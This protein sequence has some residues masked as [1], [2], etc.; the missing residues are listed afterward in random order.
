M[1]KW[2]S[3]VLTLSL[4][5]ISCSHKAITSSGF[6]G[7]STEMEPTITSEASSL[8]S[9][10]S[11]MVQQSVS[12]EGVLAE[13]ADSSSLHLTSTTGNQAW[14]LLLKPPPEHVIWPH[15]A[16]GTQAANFSRIQSS[17]TTGCAAL[18]VILICIRIW[19]QVA[20]SQQSKAFEHLEPCKRGARL[21]MYD[22]NVGDA[23]AM[24]EACAT[25][26][27]TWRSASIYLCA[28][29][30]YMCAGTMVDTIGLLFG[31]FEAE[32]GKLAPNR[33]ACLSL[34][35][36]TGQILADIFAG[37][38]ADAR[39]RCFVARYASILVV[40]YLVM[41][42][43]TPSLEVLALAR[44]FGGLGVGTMNAIFPTLLSECVPRHCRYLLVMYQFGWPFGAAIFTQIMAH[45]GWRMA[46]ASFLP[47][48]LLV[49]VIF[50]LPGWLPESPKWLCSQ[51]RFQEAAEAAMQLGASRIS[52]KHVDG[53]HQPYRQA[54]SRGAV[55][56]EQPPA[57]QSDVTNEFYIRSTIG[58]FGFASAAVLTKVW[59]PKVL[60][61]RGVQ[62]NH[63]SFSTMWLVESG[64][65]VVSGLLLGN[66][67]EGKDSNRSSILR[68]SQ[69]AVVM[70]GSS[71]LGLF[72]ATSPL[73]I[74]LLGALH[75]LG[76]ANASNFLIA[77]ATL[78]F[79]VAVRAKGVAMVLLA[80]DAGGFVGPLTGSL[81][82]Q[83][84]NPA[85]SAIG[86]LSTGVLIYACAFLSIL[87]LGEQHKEMSPKLF[88][89]NI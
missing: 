7:L 59:L 74:T 72:G 77:Y 37:S 15:G 51:G 84:L 20:S 61:L 82:I 73:L 62:S 35:S 23:D 41:C 88:K 19:D 28:L 40:V 58:A 55:S 39:G 25:A 79:P 50:W 87:G 18:L 48:A 21:S 52:R 54:K 66:P 33:L 31:S 49:F 56:E 83:Y 81:L 22:S 14:L 86:V 57:V 85:F 60:Q 6:H 38:I 3:A 70:A 76:Q 89:C 65:I 32:W 53:Q 75:L 45:T 12:S 30:G 67:S 4:V 27:M 69:F 36:T 80:Y 34:A 26:P 71:L 29:L 47:V 17:V 44:F 1:A 46:Q 5:R 8:A 2:V 78:A 64:F 16:I 42:T 10:R 9:L 11:D 13:T 68:V 43:H 24:L 63:V